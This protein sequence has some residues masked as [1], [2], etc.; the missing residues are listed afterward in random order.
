[1]IDKADI[2]GAIEEAL[3][4]AA[5]AN[6]NISVEQRRKIIRDCELNPILLTHDEL[7]AKK[8]DYLT[9]EEFGDLLK[10]GDNLQSTPAE[11]LQN[12][13]MY[14]LIQIFLDDTKHLLSEKNIPIDYGKHAKE[15]ASTANKSLNDAD[16]AAEAI[17][18]LQAVA[19]VLGYDLTKGAGRSG[20]F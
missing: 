18:T 10:K 8:P 13:T 11:R 19:R 6:P 12:K 16:I 5:A 15:T 20:G 1:M 9:D 3:S 17:E 7:L 2:P 4:N 14:Q